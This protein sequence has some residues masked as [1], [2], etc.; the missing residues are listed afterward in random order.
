[1]V[2]IRAVKA[3]AV[4]VAVGGAMVAAVPRASADV[5][6][7]AGEVSPYAIIF[8]NPGGVMLGFESDYGALNVNAPMYP[9]TSPASAPTPGNYMFV[10]QGPNH[11]LWS[12]SPTGPIDLATLM[13]GNTSPGLVSFPDG[14]WI[15]V[16]RGLT[17]TLQTNGS[18]GPVNLGYLLA[19][20]TSPSVAVTPLLNINGYPMTDPYTIAWH[21]YNDDLW[22]WT[23]PN[24][25][26]DTGLQM[27]PGTSPSVTRLSDTPQAYAQ[28]NYVVAYQGDNGDLWSVNSSFYRNGYDYHWP[29]ASGASPSIS[30]SD[31]PDAVYYPVAFR[32]ANGDLWVSAG[33]GDTGLPMMTG[34]NPSVMVTPFDAPGAPLSGTATYTGYVS[35]TGIASIYGHND[36]GFSTSF[37]LNTGQV[38]A[39]GASPSLVSALNWVDGGSVVSDA[40]PAAPAAAAAGAGAAAV[41]LKPPSKPAIKPDIVQ[42]APSS[43]CAAVRAHLKQ[44]AARGIRQ[45]TC[46]TITSAAAPAPARPR[47]PAP[48]RP[49]KPTVTPRIAVSSVC[50]SSSWSFSRTEE[51]RQNATYRITTRDAET[52]EITGAL[53]FLYSQDI[54]MATNSTQIT[55]KDTLSYTGGTGPA[56]GLPVTSTFTAGCTFP[57]Q[58][59]SPATVSITILPDQTQSWSFSYQD[60]PG[61][62]APDMFSIIYAVTDV[63]PGFLPVGYPVTYS[64]GAPVRC[65]NNTPNWTVPGCVVPSFAPTLVLPLSVYGAAAYNVYVGES[66]LPGTPGLTA[67]TP[68]TRGDPADSDPNRTVTCSGFQRFPD[69]NGYGV[70]SDSCDEYPFA[71]SQQSGGA[72]KI[73]G[74]NC[75]EIVP[76]QDQK[77]QWTFDEKNKY[78]NASPQVCVRGHVNSTLNSNVGRRALNPLYIDNRMM[79]GD[80]YT[81]Q[82]TS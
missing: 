71:S 73:A 28:G 45:V 80:P 29:M 1:M 67:S 74:S 7:V 78:I 50:S 46:E 24:G 82:V 21:G 13:A 60:T 41:P 70:I 14:N 76:R 47:A 34:T 62:A 68:L 37:E 10:W 25:I 40:P 15:A 16:V 42:S 58:V 63:I 20:G 19:P 52:N 53:D 6:P 2:S 12:T 36:T 17:G 22:L 5:L 64:A 55:E 32:G 79:I 4:T 57:C 61:T 8:Q 23:P 49:G 59:Q 48:V 43:N 54:T 31:G 72:L 18:W 65:D 51:C 26:K 9:G 81:V 56:F 69:G 33:G 44:Y 35:S 3:I 30:I 38:V 75:W 39:S 66:Y 27:A 11:H 77:G